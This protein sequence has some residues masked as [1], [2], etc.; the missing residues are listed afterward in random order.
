MKLQQSRKSKEE[1]NLEKAMLPKFGAIE[2]KAR[3]FSFIQYI[4]IK[5]GDK[6]QRC[7][8]F[9]EKF[10]TQMH[11]SGATSEKV[12]PYYYCELEFAY[13]DSLF[14]SVHDIDSVSIFKYLILTN[15]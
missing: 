1:Q 15:K 2:Y 7:N 6:D 12:I 9:K 8:Q 5:S 3:D 10:E 13:S 14:V 11:Q 4:K